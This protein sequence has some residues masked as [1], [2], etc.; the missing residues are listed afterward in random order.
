[1]FLSCG[2]P[3][4]KEPQ[5]KFAVVTPKPRNPFA[6]AA[7]LRRGGSHR[8]TRGALRQRSRQDMRDEMRQALAQ[9][10][11]RQDSP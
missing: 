4:A 3:P 11:R 9:L 2:P 6:P 5:M 7:H 10:D 8:P 1:L